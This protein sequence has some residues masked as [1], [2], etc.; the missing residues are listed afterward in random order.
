MVKEE[1]EEILV[2]MRGIKSKEAKEKMETK[3]T[4]S[5]RKKRY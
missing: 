3:M 5:R 2:V 4:R 1:E